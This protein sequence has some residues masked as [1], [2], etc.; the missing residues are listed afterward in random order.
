M[1]LKIQSQCKS[2]NQNSQN[3]FIM[4]II[5][6]FKTLQ[7]SEEYSELRNLFNIINTCVECECCYRIETL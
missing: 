1:N 3:L 4:I 2:M 5:S 6:H 7:K